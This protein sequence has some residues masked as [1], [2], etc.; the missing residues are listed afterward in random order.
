[1]CVSRSSCPTCCDPLD[2]GPP[3]FSVCGISQTGILEWV[4]ISFSSGSSQQGLNPGLLHC[5]QILDQLSHQGSLINLWSK[6]YYYSHFSNEEA[7]AQK[8]WVTSPRYM[9]INKSQS[10]SGGHVLNHS[11]LLSSMKH[12]K[13]ESKE[14]K[15]DWKSVLQENTNLRNLVSQ[16][17]H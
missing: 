3:G 11:A 12:R 1:M 4:A 16:Y 15:K 14:Q 9:A 7:E 2:C 8:V 13:F 5:M 6:Y 17:K 10:C